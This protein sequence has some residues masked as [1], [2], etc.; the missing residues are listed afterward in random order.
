MSRLIITIASL[1]A[2][3]L[4][5]CVPARSL[6]DHQPCP[7]AP[8]FSCDA[9]QNVCVAD[10]SG[11]GSSGGG[12]G[13]GERGG[14]GDAGASIPTKFSADQV[15][16]ALANCGLPHGPPDGVSTPNDEVAKLTG[17]WLL[18]PP[19]APQP[20]TL[21]APGIRFEANGNFEILAMDADGGVEAGV[22]LLSQGTWSTFCYNVD[23]SFV[24]DVATRPCP[25]T[26]LYGI[27]VKAHTVGGDD[28]PTNC[29]VGPITFESAPA[30]G[31]VI[32]FPAE[33]CAPVDANESLTFDFW[34]VPLS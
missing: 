27:D 11:G 28:S 29:F 32:D 23:P 22:G 18:C 24:P 21:F 9:S 7:C 10:S 3:P 2:A 14:G 6:G 30:R 19:A 16:A 13:G 25:G 31:H 34:L 17:V 33:W 5:A 1:I 8:G 20:K 26:S 4:A 12:S 15:Q